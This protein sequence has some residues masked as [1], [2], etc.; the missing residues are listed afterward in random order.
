M[1]DPDPPDDDPPIRRRAT[2]PDPLTPAQRRQNMQRIKARDTKPE[3]ILRRALHGAGLRYRLHAA[4]LPGRP[5]IVFARRRAVIFI[6]GCFWHGHECSRGVIP[7]TNADFW[8][9]KIAA[10]RRRDKAQAEALLAQGWRVAV[11]WECALV[12]RQRRVRDEFVG[13]VGAWLE[14]NQPNIEL[15]HI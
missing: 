6:H 13:A 4:G 3:M 1:S 8:D 11:I 12:G 7:Q 9:A 2:R 5:D 15:G 10:N 14:S